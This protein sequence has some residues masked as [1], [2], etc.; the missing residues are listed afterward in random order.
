MSV[1]FVAL[2][3]AMLLAAGSLAACIWCIRQGQY[4]DLDTPAVRILFED[5]PS[6]SRSV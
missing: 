1:L 4:E 3:I 2:P 5:E 6:H